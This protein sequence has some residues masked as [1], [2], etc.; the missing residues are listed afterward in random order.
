MNLKDNYYFPGAENILKTDQ[1]YTES[2]AGETPHLKEEGT[3]E[4]QHSKQGRKGLRECGDREE[5]AN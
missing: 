3:A 2:L 5:K 4:K 1:C